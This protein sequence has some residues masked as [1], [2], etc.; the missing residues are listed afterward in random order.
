MNFKKLGIINTILN[1]KKYHFIENIDEQI[2]YLDATHPYIPDGSL[3]T[4]KF[5]LDLFPNEL[6]SFIQ[7]QINNDINEK[8]GEIHNFTFK[9]EKSGNYTYSYDVFNEKEY[10]LSKYIA[11]IKKID[12]KI[13]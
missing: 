8:N 3:I 11:E 9:K 2:Y 13:F 6:D 10:T 1:M 12:G 4:S 5:T 7:S